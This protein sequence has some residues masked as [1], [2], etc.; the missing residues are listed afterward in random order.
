MSIF[1]MGRAPHTPAADTGLAHWWR[2]NPYRPT[3][4]PAPVETV[5]PAAWW[6][7]NPYRRTAKRIEVEGRR[8]GYGQGVRD[9]RRVVQRR[10]SRSHPILALLFLGAAVAG[11]GFT[12]MA[13]EA[14]SFQ[15]AGITVDQKIAEWRS[16]ILG[17]ST[18]NAVSSTTTTTQ[19]ASQPGG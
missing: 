9:E 13:F 4:A 12:A 1:S 5:A 8:E 11:V 19:T 15:G 7:W 6:N 17:G 10:R 2:W 3:P 16:D 14:G 18:A